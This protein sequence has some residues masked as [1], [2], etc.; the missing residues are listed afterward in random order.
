MITASIR[1]EVRSGAYYDSAVLMRLQRGLLGLPGVLD[2]GAVMGTP[3]NLELLGQSGLLT[4]DAKKS[5]VNDLVII[6]L[7]QGDKCLKF[8]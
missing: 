5:G 8:F 7:Q 4:E 2:S 1:S 6:V 3:A